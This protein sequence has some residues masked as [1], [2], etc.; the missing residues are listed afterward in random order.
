LAQEQEGGREMKRSARVSGKPGSHFGMLAGGIVV[1]D[2]VDEL[3]GGDDRR[4]RELTRRIGYTA[5]PKKEGAHPRRGAT[6]MNSG[7]AVYIGLRFDDAS[8]VRFAMATAPSVF[9]C[10]GLGEV[11]A[12]VF[13]VG[14]TE[15][16]G[17]K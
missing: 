9:D 13:D 3:A 8:L 14:F 10:T 4:G 12:N 5:P 11:D 7:L 2:G 1:E 15:H 16:V 17:L 6:P